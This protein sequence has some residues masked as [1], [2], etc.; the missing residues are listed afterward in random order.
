[1]YR[2][3]GKDAFLDSKWKPQRFRDQAVLALLLSPEYPTRANWTFD[4]RAVSPRPGHVHISD[5]LEGAIELRHRYAGLAI[6]RDVSDLCI[7]EELL[8]DRVAFRLHL[9]TR[10]C[11]SR[12]DG[13]LCRRQSPDS[14]ILESDDI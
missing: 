9:N 2:V 7:E 6:R 12:V 13:A 1:M 8:E 11:T 5:M 10:L 3:I 14:N 4:F